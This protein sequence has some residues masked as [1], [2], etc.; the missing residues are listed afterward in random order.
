MPVLMTRSADKQPN[1]GE[2]VAMRRK[3]QGVQEMRYRSDYMEHGAWV[4]PRYWQRAKPGDR[5]QPIGASDE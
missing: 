3:G 1:D 5:W 2:I 4:G